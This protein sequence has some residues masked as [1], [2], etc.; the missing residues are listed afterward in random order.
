MKKKLFLIG[1]IMIL[2]LSACARSSDQGN[3]SPQMSGSD[4]EWGY[5]EDAYVVEAPAMEPAPGEETGQERMVIQT[6]SLQVSVADTVA[7]MRQTLDLAKQLGGYVVRTNRYSDRSYNNVT[8]TRTSIVIRVPADKLEQAMEAV[9]QMSADGKN[10][11]LSESLTGDDVTS[12][13]VDSTS[14]LRNLKAAE[15]QLM[16]LMENTEDVEAT[17]SVFR[18]LTDI[19]SQIEVLEGHIKYLR[20]SSALSSLSVEFVAE[21]SLQPIEI[22]GWKPEGTAKKSLETLVRMLQDLGD[23][24]IQ[25]SI[26][27]LPF[28][29]PLGVGIYFLVR[30]IRKSVAKRRTSKLD[31]GNGEVMEVTDGTVTKE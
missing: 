20:E 24:L 30:A 1:L 27:C 16:V 2:A 14:R 8:Y 31:S 4:M 23:F 26:T 19:R 15:D 9:R 29:I 6:A 25:F 3:A 12:D 22:G 11:V 13:F 17:M 5:E 7:A 28:L 10:G 21:A 18:E